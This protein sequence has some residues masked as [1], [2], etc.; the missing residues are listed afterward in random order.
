MLDEEKIR[1]QYDTEIKTLV[2]QRDYLLKKMEVLNKF[3]KQGMHSEEDIRELMSILCYK[4]LAYCLPGDTAV[5]LGNGQDIPIQ[6]LVED[7]KERKVASLDTQSLKMTS[8]KITNFFR[9][10]SPK[11]LVSIITKTGFSIKLTSDHML[12]LLQNGGIIWKKAGSLQEGEM[13]A[14]P[15]KIRYNTVSPET[16]DFIDK[17]KIFISAANPQEA[18]FKTNKIGHF[19]MFTFP[20]N[21]S[22]EIMYLSGLI[23]SDGSNDGRSIYFTNNKESLNKA[24]V[25]FMKKEFGGH[26]TQY[27]NG[28]STITSYVNNI[29]IATIFNNILNSLIVFPEELLFPWVAGVYDGDGRSLNKKRRIVIY[30]AYREKALLIMKVLKRLGIT[31]TI[32]GRK[33]REG[34]IDGRK[35]IPRLSVYHDIYVHLSNENAEILKKVSPFIKYKEKQTLIKKWGEL[36]I[37]RTISDKVP[38]GKEVFRSIHPDNNKAKESVYHIMNKGGGIS[39]RGTLRWLANH[40]N[41]PE[42]KKHAF[43]DIFYDKITKIGQVECNDRWVYDIEVE[44]TSNFVANQIIVHNCCRPKTDDGNGKKC[45]WRDFVLKTLNISKE[46]FMA[47]KEKA[48][49]ELLPSFDVEKAVDDLL[50]SVANK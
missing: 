23:F 49:D 4:N 31:A 29:A 46:T 15:R 22:P 39:T 37:R 3:K 11:Q 10:R 43:S 32:I 16:L 30:S 40:H 20:K 19:A 27:A 9:I 38:L 17:N 33:T 44:N 26:T 18:A 35:I 45:M 6:K 24:F 8:Q 13:L 2:L 1:E 47:A 36:G 12:P 7:R 21:I 5:T 28:K 42:L 50:L 48:V 25:K 14:T 34:C 41:I